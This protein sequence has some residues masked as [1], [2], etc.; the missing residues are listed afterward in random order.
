MDF[1]IVGLKNQFYSEQELDIV[2]RSRQACTEKLQMLRDEAERLEVQIQRLDFALAPHNKLPP[3]MLRRIFELCCEEPAHIPAQN[4][5]YTISHVCSLWRQIALRTPEF[6]AN[7]SIEVKVKNEHQLRIAEQWL[8]RAGNHPRSLKFMDAGYVTVDGLSGGVLVL[9]KLVIHYPCRELHLSL[10]YARV[11]PPDE[12]FNGPFSGYLEALDIDCSRAMWDQRWSNL[13][14]PTTRL[15]N[16]LH[17]RLA[18]KWNFPN[19]MTVIP[20]NQLQYLTLLLWI[21]YSHCLDIL[22]ECASLVRCRIYVEDN[23][24]ATPSARRPVTLPALRVLRLFFRKAVFGNDGTHVEK[25][26]RFL[27]VPRLCHLTLGQKGRDNI[28]NLGAQAI[29]ELLQRSNGMPDLVSLDLGLKASAP[30]DVQALLTNAPRLRLLHARSGIFHEEVRNGIATGTLAP[31]LRS[32]MT[33]VRHEATDILRMV[34]LRQQ[35]AS[36]TLVDNTRQVAEFS[37]IEF[38]CHGYTRGSQQSSVF[39]ERLA[40]LKQAA[41]RLSIKFSFEREFY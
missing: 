7:V 11:T 15:K 17:V 27:S 32:I 18:G 39:R 19:I 14:A 23:T 10:P 31:Q 20:W 29:C 16:L 4:G 26:I 40:S 24:L 2:R 34:E 1:S 38:F 30:T 35:N 36:I 22:S 25:M 9:R 3:E 5:I 28:T 12:L 8:S 41:P 33:E 6:W 13:F 21:P 37:S